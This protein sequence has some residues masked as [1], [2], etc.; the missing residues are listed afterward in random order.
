MHPPRNPVTS[1][2]FSHL[3][4]H[5]S[6]NAVYRSGI[7]PLIRNSATLAQIRH[8]IRYI[9]A[10]SCPDKRWAGRGGEDGAGHRV[11]QAVSSLK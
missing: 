1:A 2:E 9:A 3:T 11:G 7:L 5:I 10:T 8:F 6:S 4:R